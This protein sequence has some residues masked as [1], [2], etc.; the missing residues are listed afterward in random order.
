MQR[1]YRFAAHPKWVAGHLV[2][3]AA[4]VTMV[5]L[6]RW[7]LDVSNTKHFSIQ[8]FGYALQWWIFTVFTAWGWSKILR[9]NAHQPVDE[10]GATPE[11]MATAEPAPVAEPAAVAYRRYVMPQAADGPVESDDPTLSNYNAHL[12]ALHAA[13]RE[14]ADHRENRG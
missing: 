10:A 9:D 6:G 2:V 1:G 11:A 12:A 8:N 5:L 3:L 4:L 14:K 13:D 7:Q